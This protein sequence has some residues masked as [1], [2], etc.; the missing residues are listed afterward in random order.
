MQELI[1]LIATALNVDAAALATAVAGLTEA[2][3]CSATA[4][5]TGKRCT[6]APADGAEVCHL[7]GANKAPAR[8]TQV[9][10][11]EA[12]AKLTVGF[13]ASGSLA[14]RSAYVIAE[15]LGLDAKSHTTRADLLAMDR[16]AIAALL[17]ERGYEMHAVPASQLG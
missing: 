7:H 14:R 17:A 8:V 11:R 16:D 13:R 12:T 1:T 2:Q 3:T 9:V 5:S 6:K 10:S 15:A 4:R